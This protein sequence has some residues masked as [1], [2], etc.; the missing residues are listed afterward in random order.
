MNIQ[1]LPERQV[2]SA[3]EVAALLGYRCR[4]SFS[5]SRREALEAAGFP[6]KL[7]GLNGW[8]KPA[9]MRWLENNGE[10]ASNDD[11]PTQPTPLERR[12]A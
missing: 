10:L 8:S 3:V 9:I 5:R 11:A 2:I 4:E 1:M 12:F 6:K 7:P